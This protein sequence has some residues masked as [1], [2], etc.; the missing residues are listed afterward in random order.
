[1]QKVSPQAPQGSKIL[2]IDQDPLSQFHRMRYNAGIAA[3]R[4]T[5]QLPQAVPVA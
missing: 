4:E 1:V 3:K 5:P 2:T